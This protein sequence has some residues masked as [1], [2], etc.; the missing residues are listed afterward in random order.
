[1]L[2]NIQERA[3]PKE[4]DHLDFLLAAHFDLPR[5]MKGAVSVSVVHFKL[6][7]IQKDLID[8]SR[9]IGNDH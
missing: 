8:P 3:I 1:L 4:R 5:A 9:F 7:A 2:K 6:K